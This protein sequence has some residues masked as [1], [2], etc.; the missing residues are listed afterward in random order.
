VSEQMALKFA[1]ILFVL[2]FPPNRRDVLRTFCK[3]W[4][5]REPVYRLPLDEFAPGIYYNKRFSMGEKQRI[6]QMRKKHGLTGV[7]FD[8]NRDGIVNFI[9]Y[10]LLLNEESNGTAN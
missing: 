8:V 2:S 1:L 5:A 3:G 4:L 6:W 9:D 10:A 7:P